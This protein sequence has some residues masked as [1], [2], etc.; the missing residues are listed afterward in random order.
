ML[1]ETTI[2]KLLGSNR[3][4]TYEIGLAGTNIQFVSL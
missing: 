4:K 1:Q 3:Y 2:K